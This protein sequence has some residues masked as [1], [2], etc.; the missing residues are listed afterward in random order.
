M[1]HVMTDDSW[2]HQSEGKARPDRTPENPVTKLHELNRYQRVD[3]SFR[4]HDG[5]D[6]ITHVL[7]NILHIQTNNNIF[8]SS[9]R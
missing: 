6:P 7:E 4:F 5:V 8:I 2:R 1:Y 9:P 3:P